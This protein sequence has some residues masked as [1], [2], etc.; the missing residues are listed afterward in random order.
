MSDNPFGS[1]F[2]DLFNILGQQGPDAWFDTARNLALNVARGDD[3]DPNPDPAE[4]Q[5]VE[6]FEALV[7]RHVARIFGVLVDDGVRCANRT[8]L[9]LAAL[10]Q[11]RPL[12][13][14]M[15][16]APA[17]DLSDIVDPS[18]SATLGQLAST[19]GP[20]FVGFQLGSVAGHF[21]ERA[22]SL[23]A[24]ALPRENQSRQFV[25]NN[26]AHFADEWSLDRDATTAF[27]LAREIVASVILSQPGTGDALRA[28]LIDAVRDAAA[29]QGDIL[30]KL[31]TMSDPSE[32]TALMGNPEALLDGLDVPEATDATR[33]INAAAAILR[34]VF[35]AA[36]FE[37]TEQLFGPVPQLREAYLR[38]RLADARGEDAA[39]ALFGIDT[40]GEEQHLADE[41]VAAIVKA[42]SL[43]A[44]AALLRADGLPTH[45]ELD[46]PL[47]WFERV[48]NSPLA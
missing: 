12:V 48:A 1:M 35:D 32:L 17:P 44:F 9:T 3:G 6:Q 15:I 26:V 13:T 40:H 27:A 16:E 36:A 21:S 5:R 30:S 39:A 4:R 2:G 43:E 42:H 46:A 24:L 19:I 47:A 20:L 45:D 8:E 11:W 23:A 29:A 7:S 38:Y 28:L 31:T 14:P 25:V 22:W 37:I 33:A 41:F 18:V 34:A 10:E